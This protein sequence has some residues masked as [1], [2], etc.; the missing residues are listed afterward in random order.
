MSQAGAPAA[1]EVRPLLAPRSIAVIGA[2]ASPGKAGNAM[3]RSLLGFPG[4]LHL[5][6]PSG[7]S[8]EGRPVATSARA[9]GEPVDLAVVVVPAPLVPTALDDCGAAGI[10]AAVVCAG[11][12]A[13]AAGGQGLQDELVAVARR[14]GMRL[15]GPNTSGFM[16]PGA[17][18]LANF[19]PGVAGLEPGPASVVASSGGVNLAAAFLAAEEGLGLRYGIGLGNAADV[20]FVDVLDFLATD[21]ATRVVGIHVE[22]VDDGRALCAAVARLAATRPVVALPVGRSPVG[23]IARSHTGRL[24]GDF[25]VARSALAQAGAVVVDELTEM[26]DALRAL[27]ARRLPPR[28]APGVGVVTGQAGPGLLITDALRSRGVRVPPLGEATRAGLDRLLPPLTWLGNPVDTGRPGPG[29][30]QV[31][32]LVAADAAVDALAVYALEEGDAVDPAAALRAPGVAGALPV[33][34]GTGGPRDVLDRRRRELADLGIPLYRTPDGVAR[35]VRALVEDARG[36]ARVTPTRVLGEEVV[37]QQPRLTPEANEHAAKAALAALG[38]AV[39]A[40]R[41]CP[42]RA[43]AHAAL[44]DLGGP[45]VVKVLDP[46]IGHKGAVGGVRTGVVD[47]GGMAA[48]LDALDGVRGRTTAAYLVESEVGPGPELLVGGFRDPSFGPVVA[49]GRGGAAAESQG[50]PALRLAPLSAADGAD[51]VAALDPTLDPAPLVPVVAAVATLLLGD[52]GI[53][54]IDVNPLRLTAGG[55]VALDALVVRVQ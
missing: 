51:L 35:A 34:F 11:G 2:S 50:P 18:V 17:G 47:H 31:L 42:D 37:G 5:V 53:S 48:A 14:H 4:P 12:F 28:E 7:G 3:V 44:D 13:E 45:V 43:A 9:L 24:L 27:A 15:L 20:G 21:A 39:P 40:G 36:Q 25:A 29:F 46:A 19:V 16:N 30:G 23:D 22:G 10:R 55:P 54:E 49:L 6:N 52:P 41:V 33:V 32:A 8:I 38:V 26:I 1:G